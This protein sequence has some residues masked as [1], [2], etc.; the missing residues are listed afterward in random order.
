MVKSEAEAEF[1]RKRA[2]IRVE[3]SGKLLSAL[4]AC[5]RSAM[6]PGRTLSNSERTEFAYE[7]DNILSPY[8]RMDKA[9]FAKL[10]KAREELANA[11]ASL[12]EVI[13]DLNGT[14]IRHL[15]LTFDFV[16]ASWPKLKDLAKVRKPS[17][18]SEIVATLH[19]SSVYCSALSAGLLYAGGFMVAKNGKGRPF[20]LLVPVASELMLLW[21]KF[22]GMKFPYPKLE[23]G[24][25]ATECG[26][27]KGAE[28]TSESRVRSPSLWFMHL[29][30]NEIAK[31]KETET[32]RAIIKVIDWEKYIKTE[33]HA[34]DKVNRALFHEFGIDMHRSPFFATGIDYRKF[35]DRASKTTSRAIR[36]NRAT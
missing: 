17:D 10:A 31:C 11:A 22:T 27:K 9:Y 24:A 6:G 1:R 12:E 26:K 16:S 35:D 20:N 33:F 15:S 36:K 21:T 19:F 13:D 4:F 3:K 28:S 18:F 34:L 23:K 2:A 29:C 25:R 7:L 32:E 8:K 14:N 5:M 30:L